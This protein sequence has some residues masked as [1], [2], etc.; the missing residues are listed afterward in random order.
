MSFEGETRDKAEFN[1]AVSYLNRINILLSSCDQASMSLDIYSWFH[2]LL[3]TYRELSTWMK[4][5]EITNFNDKILKVNPQITQVY[6]R[7][8]RS[9]NV[10][11]PNDLYMEL[12]N[13]ELVLR[14]VANKSGLMMKIADDAFNALK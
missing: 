2:S 13:M 9:G 4:E 11:I 8:G 14:H 5:D 1:M 7:I 6:K 12:H 10:E 3:A